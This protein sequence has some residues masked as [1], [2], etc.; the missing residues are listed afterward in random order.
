MMDY[1][2]FIGALEFFLLE[3]KNE[4]IIHYS[5]LVG[6]VAFINI[7]THLTKTQHGR[8]MCAIEIIYAILTDS[9]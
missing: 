9:L 4:I 1:L 7:Y 2:K 3:I 5:S 8:T 6:S